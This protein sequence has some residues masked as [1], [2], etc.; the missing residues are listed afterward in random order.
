MYRARDTKLD[1]D[2]AIKVLPESFAQI[3]TEWPASSAKRS[4]RIAQP[5][6]HR[7]HPWPR[8][9]GGIEAWSWNWSKARPVDADRAWTDSARRRASDRA[10]RSPTRWKR[11]TTQGI[12][13]RDLK[14]ANIKVAP[15]GTVKVLDF[16][17]AKALD[18]AA[19]SSPEAMNSPTLT[20]QGTQMGLI[21]GTAAYMAPEQARGKAVDR[22]A[23]IWAFGVVLHEML[24]GQRTFEGDDVSDTLASVLKGEVSWQALPGDLPSRSSTRASMPREGSEAALAR[25]RRSATDP[26]R[27]GIARSVESRIGRRLGESARIN[28]IVASCH[29]NRRHRDHR[30]HG[31]E[32]ADVES[33]AHSQNSWCGHS[34]SDRAAGWS[35]C[36]ETESR[37]DRA[38]AGRCSHGLRREPPALSALDGRGRGKADCGVTRSLP[39]KRSAD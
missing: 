9:V 14:P 29:P 22:R 33:A 21:I 38:V 16:G 12:V 31:S 37:G 34:V 25:H 26:R 8:G 11:R 19:A 10:S 17:L 35:G 30:R 13:H 28:L 4:P 2:V 23:D 27:S 36:A 18:P 7:P 15:D 6:Q 39:W 24:T 3:P 32:R 20:A 1:R 5:S